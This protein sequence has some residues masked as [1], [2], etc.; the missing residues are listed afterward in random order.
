MTQ[1]QNTSQDPVKD[2]AEAVVSGV[3]SA[4]PLVRAACQRHLDDLRDG[5]ARGLY[6]DL[7][8]ADRVFGFFG[9]VLHLAGGEFENQAF[10]LAPV[11]KF[12]VGS[13]FGW[14]RGK[15]GPRRFR[16]AYVE[17]GKGQGKSPLGGGLG[18]YMMCADGELRAECYAAAAVA[19]QARTPFRSAVAQVDLSPGL[20]DVIRK[21]P[22]DNPDVTKVWHLAHLDS[23]SFFKPIASESMGRG[24]SGFF[25][26][27]VLLDEVHEHPT[28]A[29]VEF[30]RKNA[31]KRRNSLVFMIT[32]SGV[33]GT[34]SVCWYY[35]EYADRVVT[36]VY[37]DDQ[38][39]GFV[40]GLDKGDD[41]RDPSV[42]KKACPML[43]IT[44]PR[45]MLEA[46]VRQA[47]GMPSLQSLTRRLNFCE[48]VES[49]D[50]WITKEVWD[51]NDGAVDAAALKGKP[52]Y[53]GLDLSKRHDLTA[54]VLVFPQD[55][56]TKDVL[57]YAW[58]PE[59]GLRE[60]EHRDKA[61]YSQWVDAGILQ[62]TPGKT[63]DY[64]FVALQIGNL[65]QDYEIQVMAFDHWHFPEM[66]RA[67]NA[68]GVT[69]VLY[70][71]PQGHAGMNA[72]IEAAE[73]DLQNA[74]LR[75]GG[76][77]LLTSCVFNVRVDKN[78]QALRMFDKKKQTARI[79]AAQ[80]MT[81]ALGVAS[82]FADQKEPDYDIFF[83]G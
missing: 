43:D 56:G 51:A 41:W 12:I 19:E 77:A 79:D 73:E 80:S 71:H 23:G 29:M 62:V 44:V 81:M 46:E 34:D 8:A 32:N 70:D 24:K 68:A 78:A 10:V 13:L 3:E 66:E 38:F 57:T 21:S 76:N 63:I 39:F 72:S 67:L 60:R 47:E 69:L 1:P 74:R 54:L 35:H 25:P 75:H 65:A 9:E 59:E 48:W 17:M 28:N 58:T 53:A 30:M 55:D 45:S 50:P 61:P 27:F 82:Q 33:V 7:P 11:Q 64:D 52:C 18:N 40:C 15:D 26:Y 22:A 6:W 20:S 31:A 16:V 2:Y 4:G 49:A 5:P 37:E 36:R 83:V 14:K 42:W